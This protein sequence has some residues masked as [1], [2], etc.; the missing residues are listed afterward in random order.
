MPWTSVTPEPS[1]SLL[2]RWSVQEEACEFRPHLTPMSGSSYSESLLMALPTPG[3]RTQSILTNGRTTLAPRLAQALSRNPSPSNG[4][5]VKEARAIPAWQ[6]PHPDHWPEDPS[7]VLGL[8]SLCSLDAYL[9]GVE[10]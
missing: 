3:D 6:L 2:R 7:E 1:K 8:A 5:R 10:D 9:V 4:P